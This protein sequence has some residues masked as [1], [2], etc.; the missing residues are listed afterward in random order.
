MRLVQLG[1]EVSRV[2]VEDGHPLMMLT[3]RNS[4]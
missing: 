3:Q 2:A 4:H 1:L